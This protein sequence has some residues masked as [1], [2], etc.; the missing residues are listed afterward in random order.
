[1]ALVF[2]Y[3]PY[4]LNQLIVSKLTVE[5]S[6]VATY[7]LGLSML[8][9]PLTLIAWC[10]VAFAYFGFRGLLLAWVGL[11]LLGWLLHR[12]T[13]RW[14]RVKQDAKLFLNVMAHPRTRQKLAEQRTALVRE[15]DE[16]A[17]QI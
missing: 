8:L 2:W 15:F 1:V 11:P 6:G 7:K 12:W 10:A 9:L 4:A 17:Q 5:E 16:L 14:H 3:P 13:G